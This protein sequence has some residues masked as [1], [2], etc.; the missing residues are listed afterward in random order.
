MSVPIR[1]LP[2]AKS[3][4]RGIYAYIEERSPEGA[5]RWRAAFEEGL[6]RVSNNPQGLGFAPENEQTH[7]E[8]RQLLFKT[9]HGL[10]YRA[11]DTM[12]DEEVIILRI[13]GPGQPPLE[14]DEMP[15]A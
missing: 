2:R 5:I 1:M 15:S 11:V 6:R 9:P 12:L 4:F 13:R 3:D 7:Y 8:L 10:T 14:A